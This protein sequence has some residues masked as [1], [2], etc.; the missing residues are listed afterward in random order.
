MILKIALIVLALVLI[1]GL[2]L[3]R[4]SNRGTQRYLARFRRRRDRHYAAHRHFRQT[5]SRAIKLGVAAPLLVQ[6]TRAVVIDLVDERDI[7]KA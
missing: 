7:D 5:V 4:T 2:D 3:V 6:A 1:I